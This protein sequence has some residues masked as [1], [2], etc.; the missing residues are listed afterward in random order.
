VPVGP[1]RHLAAG[2]GRE[3]DGGRATRR[4]RSI[5]RPPSANCCR[6]TARSATVPLRLICL[7][8]SDARH[9][10]GQCLGKVGIA[11]QRLRSRRH[12]QLDV[13]EAWRKSNSQ[14]CSCERCFYCDRTLDIHQHDHYP[15]PRRAGG[16]RTVAA[17]PICHDLKDRIPLGCWDSEARHIATEELFGGRL[18]SISH[19]PAESVFE[20][21]YLDIEADWQSL[22]P[23]AR[24]WY[25]K[26][27]SVLEDYLYMD[28][29]GV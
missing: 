11:S 15:V 2:F 13:V 18:N 3:D 16:T 19:L 25:A 20:H 24:L 12:R 7:T 9:K 26:M 23:L 14:R 5:G 6:Y 21:C 27:R 22:S 1:S 8:S 4:L 10:L 17:C 29:F 28:R